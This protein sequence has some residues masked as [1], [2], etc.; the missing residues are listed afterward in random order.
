[1][2]S[3]RR[4]GSGGVMSEGLP[5]EERAR[6]RSFV[7]I[8][9]KALFY[10]LVLLLLTFLLQSILIFEIPI[11]FLLGWILHLYRTVPPLLPQWGGLL[12]PLACVVLSA[13]L[14]HRFIRWWLVAKGSGRGWAFAQSAAL[15][16]LVLLTSGAAIAISG[17]VHQMAWLAQGQVITDGKPRER[18]AVMMQTRL[19]LLAIDDFVKTRGRYPAT[20]KAIEDQYGPKAPKTW[21]STGSWKTPEPFLLVQPGA[22]LFR[23][24]DSPV[25]VISPVIKGQVIVGF[26]DQACRIY[27]AGL[28]DEWLERWMAAPATDNSTDE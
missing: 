16:G 17:I 4:P 1:M 7:R 6:W 24:A 15:L 26:E 11:R 2:R 28:V 9:S 25:W 21:V 23:N 3:F 20:L 10:L 14:V 13:V 18:I 27:P 5:V 22:P 12:L 8:F 19:L